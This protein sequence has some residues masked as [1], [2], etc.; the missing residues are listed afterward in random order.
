MR[1]SRV[2]LIGALFLLSARS[3]VQGQ[4]P[5][6]KEI[7]T[8]STAAIQNLKAIS[9]RAEYYVI[10]TIKYGDMDAILTPNQADVTFVRQPEDRFFGGKLSVQS[11]KPLNKSPRASA[12]YKVVYDGQKVMNIG[13]KEKTVFVNDPDQ[14]GKYLLRNVFAL[15]PAELREPSP[16][17]E[18]L[19]AGKVRYSGEAIVGGVACHIIQIG[20]SGDSSLKERFWFLGAD[21]YL[22]RKVQNVGFGLPNQ[23]ITQVLTLTGVDANPVIDR[24]QF[25]V[26]APEGF[27][28]KKY[29]LPAHP[30]APGLLVG[31]TAPG[32][33]LQDASGKHYSL[34]DLKGQLVVLDF[35]ATWCGPCRQE[36]PTLQK[37]HERYRKKGVVVA[38]INTWESADPVRFMKENGYSFLLLLDGNEVAK[39]YQVSGIPT[40]YIIGPDGRILFGEV[41][42]LGPAEQFYSKLEQVI[43]SNLNKK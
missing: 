34:Q 43:I 18:V 17:D 6:P 21:D 14:S 9:Y 23:E 1:I 30:N 5:D 40:L 3:I 36:M 28:V 19:K 15:I 38:G 29:E 35:W 33:T 12:S 10:G 41:G 11:P 32:W 31:S 26:D 4:L 20:Y 16:F 27:S 22:P 39:S 7:L 42:Y 24:T 25:V 2:F 13:E 37:L 8:K